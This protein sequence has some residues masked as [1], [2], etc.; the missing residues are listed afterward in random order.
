MS[1][2]VIQHDQVGGLFNVIACDRISDEITQELVLEKKRDQYPLHIRD[3]KSSEVG[4]VK[5]NA[6][7][8]VPRSTFYHSLRVE[9]L[10]IETSVCTLRANVLLCRCLTWACIKSLAPKCMISSASMVQ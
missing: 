4:E 2:T 1:H 7:G 5:Q 8:M 9:S 10:I 6:S 3:E